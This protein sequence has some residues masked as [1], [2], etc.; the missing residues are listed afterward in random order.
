MDALQATFR[1][2]AALWEKLSPSQRLTFLAVPLIVIGGLG[3][4]IYGT[5]QPGYDHL[6]GGKVFA[7]EELRAA[8]EALNNAGLTGYTVDGQR[9]RVPKA[10]VTRYNAALVEG[11]PCPPNTAIRSSRCTARRGSGRPTP[12][13][14]NSWRSARPRNSPRFF[15]RS[16]TSKTH[17]SVGNE[18]NAVL[19]AESRRSPRW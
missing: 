9:V 10:D 2:L 3:A 11:G 5:R 4:L 16:A 17:A 13:A 6:L 18:P 7:A 14:R 12:T 15:G 8:Q 19:L 1:Q